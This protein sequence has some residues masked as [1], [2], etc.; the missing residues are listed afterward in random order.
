MVIE[1]FEYDGDMV[2]K[3]GLSYVPEWAEK[4]IEDG[5]MFYEDWDLFIKTLEGRMLAD[6]GDYIIQGVQGEI[7]PCKPDIFKATYDFVEEE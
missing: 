4:S 5:I 6:V 1:A 3:N 2:D 7:Y